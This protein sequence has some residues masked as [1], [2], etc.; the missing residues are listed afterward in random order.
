[1]AGVCL[2]SRCVGAIALLCSVAAAC[3][4]DRPADVPDG[5]GPPPD[6]AR[7]H[8]IGGTVAGLW[9]GSGVLLR[10]Q[11]EGV[12]ELAT[13]TADGAF[14]F[15][16]RLRSSAAFAVSVSGQP[17]RQMCTVTDGA[18]TVGNS[19]ID[20]VAV[21][22][23]PSFAVEVTTS[24]PVPWTFDPGVVDY[25]IDTSILTQL[26]RVTA[27]CATATSLRVNGTVVASG[28]ESAPIPLNEGENHALVDIAVAE[29]AQQFALTLRRGSLPVAQSSYAKALNADP[30]DRFGTSVAVDRD[31]I[32]VAAT[33]E[34]SGR[35]DNPNDN[36]RTDA[37][38][39]YLFQRTGTEWLQEAYIKHRSVPSPIGFGR[40]VAISGNTLAV[41]DVGH[42]QVYR[43]GPGGWTFAQELTNGSSTFG[44]HVQIL[45]DVM[46]VADPAE[47][48]AGPMFG[49]V[50]VYRWN[51]TI[52]ASEQVLRPTGTLNPGEPEF[53]LRGMA[54]GADVV[55][56]SF[57]E[58]GG[59]RVQVY[60]RSGGSWRAD[61]VL[62]PAS[63]FELADEFGSAIAATPDLIA[64]GAPGEDGGSSGIGGNRLDNTKADSGAVYLFRYS[65]GAW[66]D[67]SYMK[68]PNAGAGDRFGSQLVLDDE[69]MVIAAP[70]ED[71]SSAGVDPTP[72][73]GAAD[74]GAAY[75][76][77]RV[78]DLWMAPRFIKS[79][80][81]DPGDGFGGALALSAD[82]MVVSADREDS[83]ARGVGGSQSGNSAPDS[84]SIYVFR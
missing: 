83:E 33:G 49:A 68:A 25:V 13:R 2:S 17:S 80:N 65:G 53:G 27:K 70:N 73:E 29:I 67:D 72:N 24:A 60:R 19:D 38:A 45:D 81:P 43:L 21:A 51:G 50:H 84:G 3:K 42:V 31:R 47:S 18:G 35:G 28:A 22:C 52:W 6:A 55:A 8:G 30:G 12:D 79:S 37:G 71:S 77:R 23:T 61:G 5:G 74:S 1:M 10:L 34:D 59:P 75:V 16:A 63:G 26:V 57:W 76:Y 9:Q 11:A 46:I 36:T 64:V 58:D 20:S 69:I 40:A 44:W 14:T 4:Y 41:G 48:T 7:D 39:V 54:L 66:I 15:S 32:A 56:A 82:T 62:V 78:A